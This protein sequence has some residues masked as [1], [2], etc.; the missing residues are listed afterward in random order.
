MVLNLHFRVKIAAVFIANTDTRW[1][2]SLSEHLFRFLPT[3]IYPED[4]GRYHGNNER[5]SIKHFHQSVNFYYRVIRN[6]DI[7]A[8][9]STKNIRRENMVNELWS[10]SREQ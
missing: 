10:L 4:V 2:L 8:S 3:V 5:V 6:A 1:Y 7:V 9:S